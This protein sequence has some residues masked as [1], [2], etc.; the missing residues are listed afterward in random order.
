MKNT[1]KQPP[2]ITEQARNRE[3]QRRLRERRKGYTQELE[4]RLR[5]YEQ[6]GVHAT[7]V[8]QR[9]GR[10][11]VEENRILR[12]LLKE[13]GVSEEAVKSYTSRCRS[14]EPIYAKAGHAEQAS[15]DA[16]APPLPMPGSLSS[17]L[18]D[19]S[20]PTIKTQHDQPL[21]Y[22]SGAD[23]RHLTDFIDATDSAKLVLKPIEDNITPNISTDGT[24][25]RAAAGTSPENPTASEEAGTPSCGDDEMDCEAAAHIIASLR[26]GT[27]PQEVWPELAC[28]H[29][30]RTRIKNAQVMTLGW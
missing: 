22:R 20:K 1:K 11:V 24:L 19:I 4:R 13:V 2:Q 21:R 26:G 18:L 6:E 12:Q 30:N 15:G 16:P 14:D 17:S 8:I 23:D 27:N 3:N 5:E 7:E 29:T 28:S 9:A 25:T 10:L